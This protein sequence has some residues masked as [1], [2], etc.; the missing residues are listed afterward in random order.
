MAGAGYK[1]FNTG[2]V[3]L[4]SEVNT[5]LMQQ[6]VMVFANA[7]ARTTALSGVLAEGMVSYLQDTNVVEIYNGSAWA[8]LDD[9]NAIQNTIVDAKGDLISATAADTPARLAVGTDG[10]VLTCDSSTSTGLK[11]AAPSS[12]GMTLLASGSLASSGIDLQ[13]ISGS[14]EELKFVVSDIDLTSANDSAIVL[15]ND[16]GNNYFGY[17]TIQSGASS[18]QNYR[19][20]SNIICNYNDLSTTG[21]GATVVFN[22]YNYSNTTGYKLWRMLSGYLRST[23][24][25]ESVEYRGFW[26]DENAINRITFKS[27]GGNLFDGGTYELWGIK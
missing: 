11:W 10:Q 7:S 25:E 21:N 19:N 17:W 15:N 24:V 13:S 23:G 14:Y 18:T 27:N 20:S 3:L 26:K 16:T 22:L 4:A 9:P 8:S 12:G 2:D 6:T 1:L 5:Y